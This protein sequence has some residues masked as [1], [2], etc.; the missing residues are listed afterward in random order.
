MTA[1]SDRPLPSFGPEDPRT[2]EHRLADLR[3]IYKQVGNI[4]RH[5]QDSTLRREL[6]RML[7]DRRA[8]RPDLAQFDVVTDPLGGEVLVVRGELVLRTAV[9]E[10]AGVQPLLDAYH[11]TWEAVE[12]LDGRLVRLTVPGADGPRLVELAA[13]LRARGV[14]ASLN[15]VTPMGVVWK[16]LGGPEASAGPGPSRPA[17]GPGE[18]VRVAVIDTGIAAAQRGDGWLTG[19]VRPDNVDPLDD[20]PTPD[21]F[22]DLGAGHGTFAA[23]IVQ[24]VAPGADLAVYSALDSDGIGSKIDIASAMVR[25][26]REGAQ[27]INLSLGLEALDDRPPVAF[28]VALEI[29]DG[30]AAETGQQEALVVAAAG[31]F[32][33]ARPCWPAAL[34]G[35]LAVAALTQDLEPA[36]WSSRGFWVDCSTIGEGI[37]STYVE[38]KESPIV[39]P[40]PETF[41]ADAWAL[42]SGT[43]FAAPQVAG[44][45]ARIAQEQGTNPREALRRLLDGQPSIP[46]YGRAVEILPRT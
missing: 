39:D 21:G 11:L 40:D 36:D 12:G 8:Q 43:S 46:D 31:N 35:V 25:A 37:R 41:P 26:V 19:L 42:W 44:A 5:L 7:Q 33:H 34:D 6:I 22:L 3:Q 10:R 1:P 17:A 23:G 38:G 14:P 45:I 20:L 13:G 9:L 4:N 16:G 28:E 15:Y 30:I 2:C 18:P 29:I 27:I 32:G 24:Q